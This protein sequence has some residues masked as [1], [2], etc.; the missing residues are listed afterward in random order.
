MM[1]S[2]TIYRVLEVAILDFALPQRR[3]PYISTLT[4]EQI[5]NLEL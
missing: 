2:D 5:P 3:T 4:D 1:G